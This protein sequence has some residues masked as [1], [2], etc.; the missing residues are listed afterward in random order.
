MAKEGRASGSEP[1]VPATM[2]AIAAKAGIIGKAAAQPPP[3]ATM[4]GFVAA[5]LTA[6]TGSATGAAASGVQAQAVAPLVGAVGAGLADLEDPDALLDVPPPPLL[7]VS[8]MT[9]KSSLTMM[10][11]IAAGTGAAKPA[12][13]AKGKGEADQS[14]KARLKRLEAGS[15]QMEARLRAVEAVCFHHLSCAPEHLTIVKG[16]EALEGYHAVRLALP[17]GTD[18]SALGS[19]HCAIAVQALSGLC[20]QPF[21]GPVDDSLKSRR[22]CLTLL[23]LE[24]MEQ[25]PAAVNLWCEHFAVFVGQAFEGKKAMAKVSFCIRGELSLPT[26]L[27]L[28]PMVAECSAVLTGGDPAS[29]R[30]HARR[31]FSWED[32]VP[33]PTGKGHSIGLIVRSLMCTTGATKPSGKAPRAGWAKAMKGKGKS[34]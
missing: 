26:G 14:D 16:T 8:S 10:Q 30:S 15:Q 32:G 19:P 27:D 17:D 11:L 34:K 33:Y 9:A 28:D 24:A 22:I 18:L 31:S 6:G 2:A 3:Q 12:G 4:K 29:F 21:T 7:S 20:Q 1:K 23:V 25:S 5:T 13:K